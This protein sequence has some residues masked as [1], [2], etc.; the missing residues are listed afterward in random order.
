M[1]EVCEVQGQGPKERETNL[2][3]APREGVRELGVLYRKQGCSCR[4]NS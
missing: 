2:Q 4:C 1:G 3:K